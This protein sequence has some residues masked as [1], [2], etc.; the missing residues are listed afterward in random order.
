M[1]T[2]NEPVEHANLAAALAAFQRN[3]PKIAKSATA[4][5]HSAK[6]SY[7]YSYAPLDMVV[8]AVLP[9]LAAQGLAWTAVQDTDA[10]N[11]IWLRQSLIHAASGERIDGSTPVGR[12]GDRWQDIGSGESYARRYFLI[13]VIGVAPGGDDDDAASGATAGVR[14]AP[15]PVK[16]YL[17]VGLYD[18]ASVDSRKAAES[19]FYVARGAGHLGLYVQTPNG[20]EVMFGDWLRAV[21]ARYKDAEQDQRVDRSTGEV[22]LTEDERAA[23]AERAAVEAHERELDE[24]ERAAQAGTGVEK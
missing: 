22:P 1:T 10:S 6:G 5:V 21:G 4:D 8:E 9:L 17:P 16:Q 23:E 20:D 3:P 24:M 7:K 2:T 12:V 14:Q 19:M 18:L 13:G 11:V 15:E